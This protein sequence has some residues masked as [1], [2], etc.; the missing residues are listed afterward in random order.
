MDNDEIPTVGTHRGVPLEDHQSDA[1]LEV[2]RREIDVVLG[3]TDP[4]E[5]ARWADDPWH[6]PESRQLACAMAESMWAVAAETRA[7]RPAIDLERLHASVAG[8]GSLKW[9]DPDLIAHC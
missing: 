1:R 6:S 9:R 2:V 8:L 7:L 4:G 5:L 3:M